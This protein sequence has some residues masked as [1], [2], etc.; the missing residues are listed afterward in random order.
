MTRTK[1]IRTG[2]ARRGIVL[3]RLVLLLGVSTCLVF[4]G[5]KPSR[6]RCENRGPKKAMRDTSPNGCAEC[7]ACITQQWKRS[8]HAQSWVDPQYV[9]DTEDRQASECLPCHAPKPVLEQKGIAKPVLRQRNRHHGVDC[10][11]CHKRGGAYAGPYSNRHGPHPTVVDRRL[12]TAAVC[13]TCH[14]IEAQERTDYYIPSLDLGQKEKN[15]CDCHRPA[16]HDRLTEGHVLS[17]IHPKRRVR[18][19]SFPV[20]T[21]R[22]TKGALEVNRITANSMDGGQTEVTVTLTNRGAGHLM[23][24]GEFGHRELR[25]Q[26][27]LLNAEGQSLGQGNHSIF[28]KDE[29][30]LVP[31]EET[32]FSI[33][34]EVTSNASPVKVK[35]LVERLNR[36]RS[37]R[38]TL[39]EDERLL[40]EE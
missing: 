40:V 29:S 28:A 16:Y 22:V 25:I 4:C 7:H 14:E 2:N 31:G 38:Y 39:A 37:F 23:P 13:E 6:K 30:G 8:A 12:T 1:H 10:V 5:A 36:D 17:L 3:S 32:P 20:W 11:T 27:E 18:D 15:C 35:L 26:V 19:H 33:P 34:V 9:A 24:T 21:E